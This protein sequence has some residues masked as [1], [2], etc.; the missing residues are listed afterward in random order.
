VVPASRHLPIFLGLGG[1]LGLL[2]GLAAAFAAEQFNRVFHA[3]ED[4][5]DAT[6]LFPLGFIPLSQELKPLACLMGPHELGSFLER[7]KNTQTCL[8]PFTTLNTRLRFLISGRLIRSLLISSAL[9]GEGKSTV[10]VGL[11]QAAARMG[12]RVLLVNADLQNAQQLHHE[13]HHSQ[14]LAAL[15]A[16]DLDIHSVIQ[17]SPYSSN[18][19]TLAAGEVQSSS[20]ALLSSK[21]MQNL[22]H[23]L[24]TEFD[25]VIYDTSSILDSSDSS[26]L[27]PHVDGVILVV[28]LG[29]TNRSKVIQAWSQLKTI[30]APVLGFVANNVKERTTKFPVNGKGLITKKPDLKTLKLY[31]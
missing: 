9:P 1:I 13:L 31:N 17:Q 30:H 29:Q 7:Y 20:T 23:Q 5:Q 11:A 3:P 14:G 2:L 27:A 28:S 4:I 15:V 19:F 21:R 8:E 26:L 16:S 25:L 22:M 18:L 10:A 6:E 24:Q 12:Q